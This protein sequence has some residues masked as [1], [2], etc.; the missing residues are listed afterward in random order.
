MKVTRAS[1]PCEGQA[2]AGGPCHDGAGDGA[3]DKIR[4]LKNLLSFRESATPT[5]APSFI[6]TAVSTSFI[7]ATSITCNSPGRS[8]TC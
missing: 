5:A 6:A 2:W 3:H 1:G 8:V 4:T 7:P